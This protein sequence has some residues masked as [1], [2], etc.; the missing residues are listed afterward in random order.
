MSTH[1][2]TWTSEI[3]ASSEVFS[4]SVF[5]LYNKKDFKDEDH[6]VG[7][8]NVHLVSPPLMNLSAYISK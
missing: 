7:L 1:T 2:G 3:Y 8:A 6:V 5:Q 4:N